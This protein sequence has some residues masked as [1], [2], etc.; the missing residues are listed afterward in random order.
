MENTTKTPEAA[1][2]KM[3]PASTEISPE[4]NA[5]VQAR[6]DKEDRTRAYVLRSIIHEW[7]AKQPKATKHRAS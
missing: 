7:A 3:V 1:T 2:D 5:K 4:A 6:C